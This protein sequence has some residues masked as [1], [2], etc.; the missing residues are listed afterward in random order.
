M[1][2]QNTI[3]VI[4]ETHGF[5][6]NRGRISCDQCSAMVI[7][8]VPVHELGCPNEMHECDGCNAIIQKNVRYCE[9]CR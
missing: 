7:N 8:G 9:D 1:A 4:I 3:K 5:N 6:Y 2:K